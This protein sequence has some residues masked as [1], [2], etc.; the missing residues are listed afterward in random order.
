MFLGHKIYMLFYEGVGGFRDPVF[1]VP[2]MDTPLTIALYSTYKYYVMNDEC[3]F[4][5]IV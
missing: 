5:M 1:T 3:S 2:W 4:M